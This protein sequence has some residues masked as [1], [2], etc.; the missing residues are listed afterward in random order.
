MV[1]TVWKYMAT[2]TSGMKKL[3]NIKVR[4]FTRIRNRSILNAWRDVKD[5]SVY[6]RRLLLK[7]F[8]SKT[9][10]DH[11]NIQDSLVSERVEKFKKVATQAAEER[12]ESI[13]EVQ[14]AKL[15][16]ANAMADSFVKAFVSTNTDATTNLARAVAQAIPSDSLAGVALSVDDLAEDDSAS[17][18]TA[19]I[20]QVGRLELSELSRRAMVS[21]HLESVK[22]DTYAVAARLVDPRLLLKAGLNPTEVDV[23]STGGRIRTSASPSR[24]GTSSR[25]SRVDFVETAREEAKTLREE[26]T[27]DIDA[28][29]MKIKSLESKS[30]PPTPG[31]LTA[32]RST[33]DEISIWRKKLEIAQKRLNQLEKSVQMINES[34]YLSSMVTTST[35]PEEADV[36]K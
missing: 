25:P 9:G 30:K 11:R 15:V 4:F 27:L 7:Q 18:I 6:T 12:L 34:K 20:R 3:V 23:S 16:H 14:E 17:D 26:L 13:A 2:G 21:D 5:H 10:Q 31:A 32:G 1:L 8:A 28:A 19:T 35:S 36:E 29:K 22:S 33:S 24:P